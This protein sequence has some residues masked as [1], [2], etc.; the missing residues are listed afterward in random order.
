MSSVSFVEPPTPVRL[1][2]EVVHAIATPHLHER[3]IHMIV[4]QTAKDLKM[5]YVVKERMGKQ[6]AQMLGKYTRVPVDE[7]PKEYAAA[8]RLIDWEKDIAVFVLCRETT[9]KWLDISDKDGIV[10]IEHVQLFQ[11]EQMDGCWQCGAPA[12]TKCAKCRFARYCS[13]GCQRAHWK[14]HKEACRRVAS[15]PAAV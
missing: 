11:S 10:P 4:F 6:V 9:K 8:V 13:V 15:P 14:D 2:V 7:F 1:A 3:V 5:V 12:P